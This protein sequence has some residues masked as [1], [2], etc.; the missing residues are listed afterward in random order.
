MPTIKVSKKEI[1]NRIG[2]EISTDKLKDAMWMYLKADT[3]DMEEDEMTIKFEDTNRPELWSA[4][5]IARE[6]RSVLGLQKGYTTYDI[7]SGNYTVNV[8]DAKLK[9]IRPFIA[10]AA[11][12]GLK[13]DDESIKSLIQI[14]DKLDSNYG[15]KRKKTSI[16]I[17]DLDKIKFP[18]VYTTVEPESI[19]FTPLDFTKPATPKEILEKHP[20]GIEFGNII[21]EFDEYPVLI[22]SDNNV[23]S[24]PPIINS[25]HLGRVDKNTK[26]VFVEVTGTSSDAV[27]QVL[28]IIAT[29]LAERKGKIES[30]KIVCKH[31]KKEES[32]PDLSPL[33]FSVK[34]SYVKKRL[35]L[36]I[37][38]R[39]MK[40]ILEKMSYE[41]VRVDE[42]A[43]EINIEAPFYR[44]DIMHPVDIVE[45]IA[46]GYGYN[47]IEPAELKVP[48]IGKFDE[49]TVKSNLFRD[50]MMGLGFQETLNFV[51]SSKE[52]LFT[53]MNKEPG[54]VVEIA[55]PVSSSWD[56]V[57][58]SLLPIALNFFSMNKT[59]EFPQKIFELGPVVVPD[60]SQENMAKQPKILCA[61]V[62]HSKANF[63]EIK[64]VLD[65]L[66][67]DANFSYALHES[68]S[69]SFISGR[70]AL[71]KVKEKTVGRIGE[72][73]PQVID[74]FGLENP[75]AVFEIFAS[76]FW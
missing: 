13:F 57:R 40:H 29:A 15:R 30:V 11:V 66:A 67:N 22:D 62:S 55:N 51:L 20:K 61:A 46:I 69:P 54:D 28:N 43:D 38:A 68:D 74:N 41:V 33:A 72:I 1:E 25:V 58:N 18:V 39:E 48:T 64:A 36:D 32:T 44:K 8:D 75:A 34:P 26:N 2:K 19:E 65:K 76:E 59:V 37:S 5:G 52:I 70:H 21:K 56:V 60:E 42:I 16:G 24:M 4:E 27:F 63:T 14:Q 49:S 50:I 7:V 53:K 10:C 23:L 71:I 73:H 3:E 47:N 9:N 12:R 35:G 17:Y 45:D 31:S 6:L